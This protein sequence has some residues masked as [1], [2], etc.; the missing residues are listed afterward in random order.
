MR[1]GRSASPHPP[2]P[3]PTQA[4]NGPPSKSGKIYGD[5]ELHGVGNAFDTPLA[6][7][8]IQYREAAQ[9]S[10]WLGGPP[11]TYV[12]EPLATER[13]AQDGR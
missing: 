13:S 7:W 11:R 3:Q 2:L 9:R 12:S 6:A 10:G 5:G 4:K 8:L 1:G